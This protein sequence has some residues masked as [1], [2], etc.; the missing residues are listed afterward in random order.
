MIHSFLLRDLIAFCPKLRSNYSLNK[1]MTLKFLPMMTSL[2][3]KKRMKTIR[4]MTAMGQ[5]LLRSAHG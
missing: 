4:E 3:M 1:M 2:G 5:S